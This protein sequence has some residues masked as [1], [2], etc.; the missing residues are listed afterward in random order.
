MDSSVSS[1]P[2]L[3]P[4]IL[5]LLDIKGFSSPEQIDHFLSAGLE[6]LHDPFD[7]KGMREAVERI[8]SAKLRTQKVMIHGDYDVDGITATAIIANTLTILG[9]E[10]ETFL[11]QRD[12]DGYGVSEDA[13]RRAHQNGVSLIITAD[14][15]VTAHQ[16][17]RTA[18]SLGMDMILVDHHRIPE[19]GLPEA[20]VILNP[21]QEDCSYPCGEL[22]AGGLAFKLSQ[23]LIGERAFQ[24]L[25]LAALSTV[26]DVAPLKDENRIIV[27]YGL[28]RLSE[29]PSVGLKALAD[30][31]GVRSRPFNVGHLGF[32][33]GPRV[34]ACGR[35]SSPDIALRLLITSHKREAESLAHVLQEENKMRQ[36]EERVTVKEAI[37]D[38]ERTFHFN[39]DRVIV[40]GRNGWHQGVIGIVAARLVDKFH[41][42]AIVLAFKNGLGKASGR[43]I[44]GFHLYEALSAC[45][46]VLDEFGGH[47]LA[48]GLTMQENK[49]QQFRQMINQYAVDNSSPDTFKKTVKADL[50]ISLEA[51]KTPFLNELA[52]LEPHGAGNPRPSFLTKNLRIRNKPVKRY[53]DTYQFLVTDGPRTFEA[54]WKDL[55]G[56]GLSWLKEGIHVDA[57]YSVKTK[58]LSG[59]ET[60]SLEIK[61]IRC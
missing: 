19:E 5:K 35:M 20:N 8:E 42:P 36:Q 23:A 60:M 22:S 17:V 54:N 43:S 49:V 46:E 38:V 61:D 29:S 45:R 55:S 12:K 26:C 37:L 10:N 56:T 40:V 33:F 9:I 32:V 6:H 41:R 28:K 7:M 21:Q 25:D 58:I 13:I 11:P 57:V 4:L 44:K 34:N 52:L 31:S 18:R 51:F 50:E 27:K 30:V 48:A 47:E 3:S 59:I 14:C 53:S 24:F 16:A 39:R 2:N 1:F 15:G